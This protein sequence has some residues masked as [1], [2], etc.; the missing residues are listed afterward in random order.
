[1]GIYHAQ[2]LVSVH[3]EYIMLKLCQ[4][5]KNSKE[6]KPGKKKVIGISIFSGSNFKQR[7]LA[8][9]LFNDL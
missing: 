9:S 5:Q 2:A 7:Y 4:D 6:G 1:L 3:W 8:I